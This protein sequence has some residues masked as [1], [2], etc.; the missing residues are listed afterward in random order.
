MI[1]GLSDRG[2]IGV[3]SSE[4]EVEGEV[5]VRGD[6][7]EGGEKGRVLQWA[8]S[9]QPVFPHPPLLGSAASK[10]WFSSSR[11]PV[12]FCGG[13]GMISSGAALYLRDVPRG[14]LSSLK[15]DREERNENIPSIK[16][17]LE[18]YQRFERVWTESCV[19]QFWGIAAILIIIILSLSV[20]VGPPHKQ[21]LMQILWISTHPLCLDTP[22][23]QSRRLVAYLPTDCILFAPFYIYSISD[24]FFKKCYKIF[25]FSFG[26]LWKEQMKIGL[27]GLP[28]SNLLNFSLISFSPPSLPQP[29]SPLFP[30][31]PCFAFTKVP[32]P[33]SPPPPPPA[34][35]FPHPFIPRPAPF[36][37]LLQ[38]TLSPQI[39]SN[40]SHFITFLPCIFKATTI[41]LQ[42]DHFFHCI[43]FKWYFFWKIL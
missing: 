28:F 1:G 30:L 8:R 27:L 24:H 32:S 41:F 39:F 25:Q 10:N 43:F 37:L 6:E 15:E 9:P 5:A 13:P 14:S 20:S 34:P 18:K 23:D 42:T 38:P 4:E 2:L 40:H 26:C 17:L 22:F 35:L 7:R 19:T 21:S 36:H 29:S 33:A 3:I 11:K 31:N 12:G 16:D